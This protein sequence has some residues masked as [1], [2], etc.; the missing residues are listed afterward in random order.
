MTRN[1]IFHDQSIV[2]EINR[3]VFLFDE[4]LQ[5]SDFTVHISGDVRFLPSFISTAESH[6]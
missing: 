5:F 2:V 1:E 3:G 4:I 6:Q